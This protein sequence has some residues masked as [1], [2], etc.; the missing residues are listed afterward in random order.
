MKR[1][2][3]IPQLQPIHRDYMM[4]SQTVIMTTTPITS[5]NCRIKLNTAH[6][7][8]ELGMNVNPTSTLTASLNTI[9]YN[10]ENVHSMTAAPIQSDHESNSPTIC[11]TAVA[12]ANNDSG[13]EV[14]MFTITNMT[15]RLITITMP[16]L[17]TSQTFM[18]KENTLQDLTLVRIEREE[19]HKDYVEISDEGKTFMDDEVEIHNDVVILHVEPIPILKFCH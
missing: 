7:E 18:Y 14:E 11:M 8:R 3:Y 10:E 5:T 2:V 15:A 16:N 13:N 4:N 9:G 17:K 12:I 1:K 6:I 19:G